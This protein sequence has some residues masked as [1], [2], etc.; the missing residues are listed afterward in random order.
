M[1]AAQWCTVMP[2]RDAHC[3]VLPAAQWYLVGIPGPCW[4]PPL[5]S[6]SSAWCLLVPTA[7]CQCLIPGGAHWCPEPRSI[8]EILLPQ[9]QVYYASVTIKLL[10]C[11]MS[12]HAIRREV[13]WQVN[14]HGQFVGFSG[15]SSES[16][17][18]FETAF[19]QQA[20]H[21]FSLYHQ[22]GKYCGTRHAAL[23]GRSSQVGG[24]NGRW[25]REKNNSVFWMKAVLK[26]ACLY[27]L[28]YSLFSYTAEL[29]FFRVSE[30]S[31]AET[32][33]HS[34]LLSCAYP[35]SL[36]VLFSGLRCISSWHN[37][38]R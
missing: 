7:R 33:S 37:F 38:S 8:M 23:K 6:A 31:Y 14:L 32:S 34:G 18:A 16:L 1:P 9:R 36:R 13:S 30:G 25:W 26:S 11:Y 21:F 24:G 4:C 20:K 22:V 17:A 29:P 35:P 10:F 19:V 15:K 12:E 5:P 27:W 2:S 3:R 28:Y